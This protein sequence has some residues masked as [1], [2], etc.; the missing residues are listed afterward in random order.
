MATRR[1]NAAE[2]ELREACMLKPDLPHLFT[3]LAYV[4]REQNKAE[5]AIAV[6]RRALEVDPEHLHAAIAE[7]L[8]RGRQTAAM[9]RILDIEELIAADQ[10][11]YVTLALRLGKAYR[12]ELPARIHGG[13]PKLFDRDEPVAALARAFE[14]IAGQ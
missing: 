6:L 8:M 5:A 14:A 1:F 12:A 7:A 10:E 9:L 3:L 4:L 11:Q 13:L 2:I